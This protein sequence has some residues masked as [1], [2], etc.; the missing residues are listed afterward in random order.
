[1][2]Q[3]AWSGP[4]DFGA[5]GSE[6]T[7]VAGTGYLI[8]F[9]LPLGNAAEMRA[10]CR[11]GVKAL[12]R[13]HDVHLLVLK[14][15]HGVDRKQVGVACPKGWRRFEQHRSEEHTSELQSQSH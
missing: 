6:L 1:M 9:R 7:P 11:D 10:D 15:R 13:P 14:V 12:F 3:R 2:G 4:F 5:I 8:G